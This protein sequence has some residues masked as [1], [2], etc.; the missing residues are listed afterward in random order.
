MFPFCWCRDYCQRATT[1]YLC[2]QVLWNSFA[3]MASVEKLNSRDRWDNVLKW[4]CFSLVGFMVMGAAFTLSFPGFFS[5]VF[6]KVRKIF[7]PQV[8]GSDSGYF[9][10]L[11]FF[12]LRTGTF[13]SFECLN[14]SHNVFEPQKIV[15]LLT[16]QL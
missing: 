14:P 13:V 3:I 4:T 12:Y 10:C 2:N 11:F 16:F 7:S 15:D 9:F 5:Y 6:A 8:S 1:T